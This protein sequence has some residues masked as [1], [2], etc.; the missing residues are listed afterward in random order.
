[1]YENVF[2]ISLLVQCVG[3]P[4]GRSLMVFVAAPELLISS[5]NGMTYTVSYFHCIAVIC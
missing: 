1:M 5:L 4:Y 2:I 3:D